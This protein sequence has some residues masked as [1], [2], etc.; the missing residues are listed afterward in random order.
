MAIRFV[1]AGGNDANDGLDNI[2]VG[3]ATA[4]WVE[5]TKR[6]VQAGHGYTFVAGDVIYVSGG[7]GVTPGLYEVFASSSNF[8]ALAAASSLLDVKDANDLAVGDLSTGDITSSDGP[9]LTGD[10]GMNAV[11]AGD[12]CYVRSDK[13]YAELLTIDT[14]G[15]TTSA[16]R[17]VG[18]TT[19][20][21]DDGQAT[22]TGSSS[23]LNCLADSLGSVGAYYVFENLKFIDATSAGI[24]LSLN[25]IHWKNCEFNDSAGDGFFTTGNGMQ[26]ESCIF[27]GNTSSGFRSGTENGL[28]GCTFLSCGNH[29]IDAD[30]AYV[31]DCLFY[32]IG[33]KAI[34]LSGANGFS[35]IVYGCTIDGN[36]KNTTDGI[37]FPVAFWGPH[38]AINN[39]IYDVETGITGHSQGNRRFT[40]RNNLLNNNTTD[41]A[42]TSVFTDK[43]EVTAAPGFT[44]EASQDYTLAD[45]SAA[46][47]AGF[48][49]HEAHGSTQARDIGCLQRVEGGG[50]GGG[51][52]L[53]MPN[54]RGGKQ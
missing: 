7:T 43:G 6:L 10:A 42:S 8:I 13:V 35:C 31:I 18:Y 39:I 32:D 2:G 44:D 16:I 17:F 15:T 53:L 34:T 3:L 19:S 12:T 37:V 47:A 38:T 9:L 11:A 28:F 48:D 5:A 21:D 46:K 49:A 41:Y 29:G 40:S 22:I 14:V 27:S 52:G 4:T 50:G 20:L 45:G 30:T 33:S 23:R 25:A 24:F 1:D 51:G 54:K 26:C 36:G